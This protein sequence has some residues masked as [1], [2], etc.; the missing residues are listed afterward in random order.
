MFVVTPVVTMQQDLH[1]QQP[2]NMIGHNRQPTD[3]QGCS[4]GKH[5]GQERASFD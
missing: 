3:R 1:H 2:H 5:Y 4:G